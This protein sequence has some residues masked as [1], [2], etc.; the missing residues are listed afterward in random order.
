MK[1]ISLKPAGTAQC[2][3]I[4]AANAWRTFLSNNLTIA[5]I[6][7]GVCWFAVLAG[8]EILGAVAAFT[9]L[10]AIRPDAMPEKGGES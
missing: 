1:A 5:A 6:S 4:L 8:C 3:R 2:I 7:A 9:A 10:A